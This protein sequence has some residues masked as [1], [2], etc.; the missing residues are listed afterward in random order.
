MQ[1]QS[2]VEVTLHDLDPFAYQG[3]SIFFNYEKGFKIINT[4][5]YEH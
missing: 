4:D 3:P 5:S 1:I 2:S